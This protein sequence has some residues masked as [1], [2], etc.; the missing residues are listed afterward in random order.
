MRL[1]RL[2]RDALYKE[3]AGQLVVPLRK[4]EDPAERLVDLLSELVPEPER[5][6]TA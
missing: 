1:R 2:A 6:A 4:G 5:A 3:E